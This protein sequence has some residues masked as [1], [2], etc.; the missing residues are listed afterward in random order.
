MLLAGILFRVL[1]SLFFLSLLRMMLM[2]LSIW[3][4]DNGLGVDRL[5]VRI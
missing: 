2:N 1:I 3:M 4:L 5:D